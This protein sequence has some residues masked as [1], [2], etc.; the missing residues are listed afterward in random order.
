[1]AR[2]FRMLI[3][4]MTLLAA[5]PAGATFHLMEIE[6]VIGGVGGDTSAQAIQLRMRALGQNLLAGAAQ[7]VVRDAAGLNPIVI[8]TFA[9]PNPVGGAC[10]QIL[11][12]TDGFAARTTPAAARDY[13]MSPIPAAYLA[14]GSLTFETLG[15]AA[16]WWRVSWGGAAYTGPGTVV[17][18]G[19]NDDDGTANPPFAGPLPAGGVQA[20]SFTPA[21]PTLSSNNAAQY[22]L[23]SGAAVFSNN[24]LASFTV[25]A[26]PSAL[27]MLS[28]WGWGA[29]AGVLGLAGVVAVRELRRA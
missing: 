13:A 27:P 2:G 24:A 29:L 26:P 3:V 4:G 8:A 14:A 25:T 21:C 19:G 16:T 20:L 6:Q 9:L 7:V 17:S 11:L 23:T 18:V 22:A 28:G 1:M 10:R 5:G 15:G 12:A